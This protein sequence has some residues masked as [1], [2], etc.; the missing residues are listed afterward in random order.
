[1][2][3]DMALRDPGPVWIARALSRSNAPEAYRSRR[4]LCYLEL[5][6]GAIYGVPDIFGIRLRAHSG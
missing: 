5:S 2:L 6:L 1:M 3:Y 4:L